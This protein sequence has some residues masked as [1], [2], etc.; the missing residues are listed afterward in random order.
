MKSRVVVLLLMTVVLLA[1]QWARPGYAQE[2]SSYYQSAIELREENLQPQVDGKLDEKI[3]LLVF[4]TSDFVTLL[5]GAEAPAVVGS[6]M[7]LA[8]DSQYLY[9]GL[10]AHDPRPDEIRANYGRRDRID[11]QDDVFTVYIDPNDGGKLVQF[12]TINANGML[13]DGNF[14]VS[15]QQIDFGPDYAFDGAAQRDEFGWTAELKIPIKQ[16]HFG[17]QE[18]NWRLVVMRTY[19]RGKE[20]NL[21][22]QPLVRTQDCYLCVASKLDSVVFWPQERK[23]PLNLKAAIQEQDASKRLD[24]V[25]R[26]NDTI[27]LE[28]SFRTSNP[29]PASAL[30]AGASINP[31][32]Q[33]ASAREEDRQFLINSA[34]FFPYLAPSN[35]ASNFPVYTRSITDLA[36][37][38]RASTRGQHVEGVLLS[39][40]DNGGGKVLL[41]SSYQTDFVAQPASMVSIAHGSFSLGDVKI[42]ALF[43]DRDYREKG[44]NRVVGQDLTWQ[45]NPSASIRAHWLHSQT[46]ARV[47]EQGALSKQ[48]NEQGDAQRIEY[49]YRTNNWEA[50]LYSER[51]SPGFRADN[52]F[53]GQAGYVTEF[54]QM[55]YKLGNFSEIS[56]IQLVLAV[57]DARDW[58]SNTLRR[59]VRPSFNFSLPHES[60]LTME[61]ATN[62]LQRARVDGVLHKLSYAKFEFTSVP[63][64][65]MP[66]LS[67]RLNVGDKVDANIDKKIKGSTL[68]MQVGFKPWP[69]VDMKM[70]WLKEWLRY[71]VASGSEQMRDSALQ[72]QAVWQV[73]VD[74]SLRMVVSRGKTV[75]NPA[76]YEQNLELMPFDNSLSNSVSMQRRLSKWVDVGIGVTRARTF[77]G[78]NDAYIRM[79]WKVL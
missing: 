63:A 36:W 58:Q 68:E 60:K 48:Q 30:V 1:N 46:T 21:R 59:S 9:I 37:G 62:E 8:Y 20:W 45:L 23:M 2:I 13:A 5:P 4:G 50:M 29:L 72:M 75:R 52:G 49:T 22:S 53:F 64:G 43:S 33:F 65:W 32:R 70:Y 71:P 31:G 51:V 41:P 74:T 7:M 14:Y 6:D 56:D 3:W 47:N 11:Q 18:K 55:T 66:Y 34:D 28:G 69:M 38:V 27:M 76:L 15:S 57:Q 54:A 44:Y 42:G 19:V 17:R 39:S 25:M 61:M 24:F 12:F 10:R 40:L 35:Q 16:L 79:Q 67:A 26:P 73:N 77:A 78:K